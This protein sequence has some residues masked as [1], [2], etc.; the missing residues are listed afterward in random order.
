MLLRCIFTQK[1]VFSKVIF[2]FCLAFTFCLLLGFWPFACLLAFCLLLAFWF[3]F[4][5]FIDLVNLA[6]FSSRVDVSLEN[7]L[8]GQA[9]LSL[10]IM[11]PIK[12]SVPDFGL[13]HVSVKKNAREKQ[14]AH[15]LFA[16]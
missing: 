9:Y 7:D 14:F 15:P 3:L 8:R 12:I 10:K 4:G 13:D 6:P 11:F 16:S 5:N 2:A 1:K